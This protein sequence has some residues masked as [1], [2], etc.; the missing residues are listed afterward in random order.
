[1][2]S[3]TLSSNGRDG[4]QPKGHHVRVSDLEKT[5]HNKP[6]KIGFLESSSLAT[7]DR[8]FY[9]LADQ[10]SRSKTESLRDRLGIHSQ[11]LIGHV[12]FVQANQTHLAFLKIKS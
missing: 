7:S 5:L 3:S 11:F 10:K 1:M 6:N 4:K 12:W 9:F 2:R 8:R